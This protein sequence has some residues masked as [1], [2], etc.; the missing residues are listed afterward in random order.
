[1]DRHALDA[2]R[3][4]GQA[5]SELAAER[6]RAYLASL[7]KEPNR[8]YYGDNLDVL[9]QHVDDAAVD[10]VYLDPRF[11]SNRSYTT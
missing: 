1:M 4:A 10:L 3:E 5:V 2:A 8:L 6:S 7:F 9:R 11:N